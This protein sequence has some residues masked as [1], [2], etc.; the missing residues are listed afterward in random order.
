MCAMNNLILQR[1]K[2]QSKKVIPSTPPQPVN[3]QTQGFV[4]LFLSCFLGFVFI[5]QPKV[6]FLYMLVCA[7]LFN[8]SVILWGI[9]WSISTLLSFRVVQHTTVWLSHHDSA[10]HLYGHQLGFHFFAILNPAPQNILVHV[11]WFAFTSVGMDSQE[12]TIWL[13][14]HMYFQ[15]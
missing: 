6:I 14:R 7:L 3:R 11:S 5:F 10:L 4:C 2:S 15:P 8:H 13:K 1:R 9:M 12:R